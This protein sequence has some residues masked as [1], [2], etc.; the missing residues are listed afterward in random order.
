M[1]ELSS[2]PPCVLPIY[3]LYTSLIRAICDAR[4]YAVPEEEKQRRGRRK[5]GG[6]EVPGN[7]KSDS[8]KPNLEL[9]A[10]TNGKRQCSNRIPC[11]AAERRSFF[12]Y[13]P[14]YIFS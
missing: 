8:I 7:P 11:K 1:S 2:M 10:G 14:C 3:A 6:R 4:S 9:T 5:R 12:S 13:L